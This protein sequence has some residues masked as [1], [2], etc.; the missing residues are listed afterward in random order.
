MCNPESSIPAIKFLLCYN[1]SGHEDL[2]VA[3]KLTGT[4]EDEMFFIQR[5][6]NWFGLNY[7]L[8]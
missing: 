4:E 6:N 3:V 7:F 2:H 1:G 8:L 5:F